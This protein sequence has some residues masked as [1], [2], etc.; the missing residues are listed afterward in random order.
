MPWQPH[1]LGISS[2]TQEA[3]RSQ[4]GLT[5]A[6]DE[7]RTSCWR[8]IKAS[9]ARSTTC[10]KSW[11]SRSPSRY[12][13]GMRTLHQAISRPLQGPVLGRVAPLCFA[14]RALRGAFHA[15][16]RSDPDR[17][18]ARTPLDVDRSRLQRFARLRKVLCGGRRT[19]QEVRGSSPPR[20]VL[21][22]LL[23]RRYGEA[24]R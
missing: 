14:L 15:G 17:G 18:R 7:D 10:I 3:Y 13:R 21:R 24:A 19:D 9:I 12:V 16:T 1:G 11:S 23:Q 8:A 6:S 4:A 22:E 20:E 2:L 5:A